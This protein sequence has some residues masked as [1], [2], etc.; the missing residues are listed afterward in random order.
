MRLKLNLGP[1]KTLR[2]KNQ[3]EIFSKILYNNTNKKKTR[4][5]IS[6]DNFYSI[7][8]NKE[9]LN[10]LNMNNYSIIEYDNIN[11]ENKKTKREI[12]SASL[13]KTRKIGKKEE[14]YYPNII[15]NIKHI[16]QIV[17]FIEKKFNSLNDISKE[18]I[19]NAN[20]FS[21]LFNYHNQL[22]RNNLNLKNGINGEKTDNNVNI[23][24][25][26]KNNEL[27]PYPFKRL[28]NK[29]RRYFALSKIKTNNIN[30][31]GIKKSEEPIASGYNF[32]N[33]YLL[34]IRRINGQKFLENKKD[35]YNKFRNKIFKNNNHN[36]RNI[37]K[38]DKS[39]STENIL[40]RRNYNEGKK[41]NSLFN[42]QLIASLT[43]TSENKFFLTTGDKKNQNKRNESSRSIL[44]YHKNY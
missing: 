33:K 28:Q 26:K 35:V 11:K 17:S 37:I 25:N 16:H 3:L 20:Y 18:N 34:K 39:V 19:S 24:N 6:E 30:N 21:S 12:R 40:I 4:S 10:L 41:F 5:D 27:I 1:N 13:L 8:N 7:R 38:K 22:T 14:H 29:I 44:V 32:Q 36:R 31:N 42:N 15:Y 43:S 2:N 23:N 9:N